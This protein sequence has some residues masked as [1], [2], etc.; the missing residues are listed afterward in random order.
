M[1]LDFPNSP[2]P[3]QSFSAAGCHWVWD[4]TKWEGATTNVVGPPGPQ[5]PTGAQG[6]PGAAGATGPQGTPG[7]QGPPGTSGATTPSAGTSGQLQ[8]SD[9]AGH[10]LATDWTTSLGLLVSNN[11]GLG[12]PTINSRSPGTKIVL[13]QGV[14]AGSA[15]YAIGMDSSTLWFSVP[16]V[17]TQLSSGTAA[18]TWR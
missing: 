11:G 8:Y 7:P 17:N 1:A 10:F 2:T 12:A 4:G 5:G 3:G 13:W 6:P 14:G 18:T 9:G 16:T 15:D